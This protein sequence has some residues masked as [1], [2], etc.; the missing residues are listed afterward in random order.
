[1][2][3]NIN[4][5]ITKLKALSLEELFLLTKKLEAEYQI[6][7]NASHLSASFDLKKEEKVEQIEKPLQAE[8]KTSFSLT[9]VEV[10][11]D[12]KISVIKLIRTLTGLGLKDCKDIVDNPPK[13]IKESLS[14]DE[15]EKFKKEFDSL[16][17]KILVE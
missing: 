17:V 15:I 11:L 12:K 1:M 2:S 9:L 13:K 4:I 16:E 10:P 5:I 3:E 6:N 7:L 8:E 14:K